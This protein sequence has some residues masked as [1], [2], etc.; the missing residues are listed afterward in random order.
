MK[1]PDASLVNGKKALVQVSSDVL[2]AE[3][4]MMALPVGLT[5]EDSAV[6]AQRYIDNWIQD[7]L[8]YENAKRNV[9]DTREIEQLVEN[10]RRS[11]YEHEYQRNLIQQ[12]FRTKISQ[13]QVDSF[14]VANPDLFILDHTVVKGLFLIVPA[15]SRD[16]ARFRGLYTRTDDTSFEEIE[17]LSIRNAA[18]CEF[19]YDSWRSIQEIEMMIP[20]DGRLLENAVAETGHFEFSDNDNAYFLHVSEIVPKGSVEPLENVAGRI[21]GLLTNR[22]EVDYMRSVKSRLYEKALKDHS[23]IFFNNEVK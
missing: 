16:I 2:Y 7:V 22:N 17:K 12:K 5:G 14:Y 21:R 19:F 23:I 1:K 11:L 18:R 3:D 9:P 6:F 4:V 10:Y 15:K 8:F 13:Q 20:V